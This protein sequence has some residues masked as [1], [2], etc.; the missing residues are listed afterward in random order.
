MIKEIMKDEAFLAQK[1][2]PATIDDLPLALDLTDTLQAHSDHCVGMAANMI[3]VSKNVIIVK[4]GEKSVVMFNPIITGKSS[5]Y[6]TQESCLS[7]EGVRETTRYQVIDV[8]YMDV[9]WKKVKKRFRGFTAQIVQHEVD[10]LNGII[11]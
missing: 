4:I 6:Q 3:G 7:L 2:T 1:S 8:E 10:H 11:I 5:P 9:K